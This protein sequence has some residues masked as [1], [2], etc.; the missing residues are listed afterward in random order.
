[1]QRFV[2]IGIDEHGMAIPLFPQFRHISQHERATGMRGLQHIQLGA[3]RTRGTYKDARPREHGHT[4]V[5][6]ELS[7]EMHVD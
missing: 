3:G 5:C 2:I 1:M 6:R 7:Q 4:V